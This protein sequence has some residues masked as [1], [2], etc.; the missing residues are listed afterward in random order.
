MA[1][2][3]VSTSF[4]NVVFSPASGIAGGETLS[5]HLAATYNSTGT[6]ISETGTISLTETLTTGGV[7]TESFTLNNAGTVV[8]DQLSGSGINYNTSNGTTSGYEIFIPEASS[9]GTGPTY[10]DLHLDWNSATNPVFF[11][12][13]ETNTTSGN[14]QYSALMHGGNAL[15][16]TSSGTEV[17]TVTILCFYAGVCLATPSGERPV[18]SLQPG[19][20]V[21]T[22]N[23]PMKVLWL[24]QS[25]VSTRFADPL[26]TLPIRITAG[27][28]G[29]G[30]PKR[31]LLLSPDHA[32][33]LNNILVQASALV[34]GTS[35]LREANVPECFTYY[36]V[37][38]SSH[39]LLLAEGLEAESFV[40]NAARRS[41]HNWD[42]RSAP[43]APIAEMD[44]P[45][46]KSARQLP[47]ALR[48]QLA[49]EAA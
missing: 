14:A 29:A 25:H 4:S 43:M 2:T 12:G 20:L 16:L 22:R 9:S 49:A 37:E 42:E 46:V 23:G 11:L 40:D 36:H 24:G 3:L 30:L 13:Q 18:E 33:C 6:L 31:D 41:F 32:I 10:S 17:S 19:D 35:I 48:Q 21:L 47:A 8:G 38:L 45:R 7:T 5:G 27:A 44:M 1:N 28:L 34:N 15:T 39:E 26:R